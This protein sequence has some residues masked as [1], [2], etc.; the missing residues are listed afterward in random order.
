[1]AK[2]DKRDKYAYRRIQSQLSGSCPGC[3]AY[4]DEAHKVDKC[5]YALY[6]CFLALINHLGEEAAGRF[7]HDIERNI[8]TFYTNR[9]GGKFTHEYKDFDLTDFKY[10]REKFLKTEGMP[11][12][13]WYVWF[14][15][16]VHDYNSVSHII[17][18]GV[19]NAGE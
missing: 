13:E 15:E 14:K 18:E 2:T 4:P 12:H 3:L 6:D 10:L 11:S 9:N 16:A 17:W 7:M 1:M 5:P 19:D 8:I